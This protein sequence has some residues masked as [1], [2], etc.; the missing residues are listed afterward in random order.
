MAQVSFIKTMQD[1]FSDPPHGRKVTIPEFKAL[2]Q[3]DKEDFRGMLIAEGHD[4]A[5]LVV[6]PPTE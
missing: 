4:V 1:F 3:K 6:A 5:E 2:T